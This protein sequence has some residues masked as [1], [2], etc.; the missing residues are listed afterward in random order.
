MLLAS[1]GVPS[2]LLQ[3]DSRASVIEQLDESYAT[4]STPIEQLTDICF[5]KIREIGIYRDKIIA[6][7]SKYKQEYDEMFGRLGLI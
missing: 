7:K 3:L 2:L 4:L 5:E 1:M 6:L